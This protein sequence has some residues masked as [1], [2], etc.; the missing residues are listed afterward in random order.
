M[1]ADIGGVGVDAGVDVAA[2]ICAGVCGHPVGCAADVAAAGAAA[3]ADPGA[4]GVALAEKPKGD[5]SAAAPGALRRPSTISS[6][7]GGGRS[8]PSASDVPVGPCA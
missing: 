7:D 2:G 3:D 4:D 8:A 1:A 5:A 6:G